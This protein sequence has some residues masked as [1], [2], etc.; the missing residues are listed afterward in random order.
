MFD[1]FLW[2]LEPQLWEIQEDFLADIVSNNN[3]VYRSLRTLF[4]N[5]SSTSKLDDRF[6]I[7]VDRFKGRL[8][9]KFSWD[10]EDLEEEEDD[11]APVIV[12]TDIV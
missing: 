8:A 7:R 1:S 10:F 5:I 6:K 2:A 12:E 3:A 11:E 4:R 9:E